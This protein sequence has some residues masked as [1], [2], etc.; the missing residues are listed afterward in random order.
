MSTLLSIAML[1][2]LYVPAHAADSAESTE[3]E[4]LTVL[5]LQL[6]AE[7]NSTVSM[8]DGELWLFDSL[9]FDW[10]D[11]LSGYVVPDPNKSGVWNAYFDA[12]EVETGKSYYAVL[13]PGP[14]ANVINRGYLYCG[15]N[16]QTPA[17]LYEEADMRRIQPI[18]VGGDTALT[19]L[20]ETGWVI[21][22]TVLA[23]GGYIEEDSN[24]GFMYPNICAY[25]ENEESYAYYDGFVEIRD[26][27]APWVYHI[28]VPKEASSYMIGFGNESWIND[29]YD[30]NI[31]FGD[32]MEAGPVAVSGDTTGPGLQMSLVGAVVTGTVTAPPSAGDVE[33]YNIGA[34]IGDGMKTRW[35]NCRENKDGSWQ[36]SI[37]FSETEKN[38]TFC[39]DFGFVED[40]IHQSGYLAGESG[41][42]YLTDDVSEAARF[43]V[44]DAGISFALP[45]VEK[46]ILS[47]HLLPEQGG[48]LLPAGT[49]IGVELSAYARGGGATPAPSG[50]GG[51]TPAPSGGG[52]VTPAPSGGG[53]SA[54]APSGGSSGG[55]STSGG[56]GTASPVVIV[57]VEPLPDAPEETE[58]T[59]VV[60][61]KVPPTQYVSSSGSDLSVYRTD[62]EIDEDGSWRAV[63]PKQDTGW[64]KLMI[65]VPN[66]PGSGV[67]PGNYWYTGAD[68][69]SR[70]ESDAAWLPMDAE[71][72][73]VY[74]EA[75]IGL[76]GAITSPEGTE[77][78]SWGVNVRVE[79]EF[80]SYFY[81][82]IDRTSS[83]CEYEFGFPSSASDGTF[84]LWLDYYYWDESDDQEYDSSGYL[85]LTD[86]VASIVRDREDATEFS[87]ADGAPSFQLPA[88]QRTTVKVRLVSADGDEVVMPDGWLRLY[89]E[90][91]GG[92]R[93]IGGARLTPESDGVWKAALQSDLLSLDETYCLAVAP[94]QN[95]NVL[96][97]HL[98]FYAGEA[99]TTPKTEHTGIETY[100]S[101]DEV[102]TLAVETGWVLTGSVLMP[103]DGYLTANGH[104]GSF[105]ELSVTVI[106]ATGW[107][108][109]SGEA[110]REAGSDRWSYQVTVPKN[111]ETV[112]QVG[113]AANTWINR[114]YETNL[115]FMAPAWSE[116][117]SVNGSGRG[118]DVMLD[119]L[120]PTVTGVVTYPQN[121]NATRSL[122]LNAETRDGQQYDV[123]LSGTSNWLTKQYSISFPASTATSEYRLYVRG[124]F[125]VEG[126]WNDISGWLKE[127]GGVY[128]VE[129]EADDATWFSVADGAPSFEMPEEKRVKLYLTLTSTTGDAVDASAGV[130]HILSEDGTFGADAEAMRESDGRLSVSVL[131][132][133]L[134]EGERYY[135]SF[136]PTG[137]S[138]LLPGEYF[139]AGADAESAAC[140][141]NEAAPTTLTDG[142][143]YEIPV[144]TGW[145]FTG[146]VVVPEGGTV[147]LADGSKGWLDNVI[148]VYRTKEYDEYDLER[149]SGRLYVGSQN[150]PLLYE[151]VLP[152]EDATYQIFVDCRW[153]ANLFDSNVYLETLEP[154]PFVASETA[155]LPDIA[156]ERIGAT[157]TGSVTFPE[158]AADGD[159]GI[160]LRAI[161]G[162]GPGYN[163]SISL[164]ETGFQYKIEFPESVCEDEYR[165]H[166]HY[167]YSDSDG[168]SCDS[169]GY[170]QLKDG[171][172]QLVRDYEAATTFHASD[173]VPDFQ[174][175]TIEKIKVRVRL[176]SPDSEEVIMVNPWLHLGKLDNGSFYE[177]AQARLTA[178]SDGTWSAVFNQ[179]NISP[180]ETY[181][182][183]VS[184]GLDSNVID[185]DY[186]YCGEEATQPEIGWNA[187]DRKQETRIDDGTVHTI[188]VE[189]GWLITGAVRMPEGGYLNL[190]YDGTSYPDIPVRAAAKTEQ[191]VTQTYSGI[192]KASTDGG[193]WVYQIA[194]PKVSGTVYQVKTVARP[195]YNDNYDTN[196]AFGFSAQSADLTVNG[197]ENGADI[198]LE[199]IGPTV[200]GVV[201]FPQNATET[202]FN[203]Y[204]EIGKKEYYPEYD[205]ETGEYS[206]SFPYSAAGERY[207]LRV[208]GYYVADGESNSL[209]GWLKVSDGSFAVVNERS[210]A[211]WFAVADGA[212]SFE[213]PEEQ[214]VKIYLNLAS[215][216]G[217]EVDASR[218]WV[219][220]FAVDRFRMTD[221]ELK[222]EADGRWS[223]AI[224]PSA[225]MVDG[226][227]ICVGFVPSDESNVP[228]GVWYNTEEGAV[229]HSEDQ[230]E[231]TTFRDGG[232]YRLCVETGWTLTGR[233]VVP[234][235]AEITLPSS[236]EI[237]LRHSVFF[238][239][240]TAGEDESYWG[241]IRIDSQN[242]P[243]EYRVVLPKNAA[244]YRVYLSGTQYAGQYNT[245]VYLE[246]PDGILFDARDSAGLPDIALELIGA[247]LTGVIS[248]SFP[249]Q[250]F[251]I[252][253]LSAE[254]ESG[255]TY[256][257]TSLN[258]NEDGIAYRIDLP[259]SESGGDYRLYL[260][261]N[262]FNETAAQWESMSGWLLEDGEAFRLTEREGTKLRVSDGGCSAALERTVFADRE[263][264]AVIAAARSGEA[265][266]KRFYCGES[267]TV[268]VA[269]T[270][271]GQGRLL[272]TVSATPAPANGYE[273]AGFRFTRS[274]GAARV[275]FFQ[276]L[277]ESWI[278]VDESQ[279]LW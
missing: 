182:L 248:A 134:P 222:R 217:D 14:G 233:V 273:V 253:Y 140:Y 19:F 219:R 234:A 25:I 274:S 1:L 136:D 261:C 243:W 26:R 122:Y 2:S 186:F 106:D 271:D 38:E 267:D 196:L 54:P 57:P 228:A 257:A 115:A 4:E 276:F 277:R 180:D 53:G 146:R 202:S 170:L 60:S 67:R 78:N 103:A 95:T 265:I 41:S 230:A 85:R 245:N 223:A 177:A 192:A 92:Y 43:E 7:D 29:E 110:V 249:A 117:F 218:S 47:G 199:R 266:E 201:S 263:Q 83:R 216:S 197:S 176:T 79:P 70:D 258:E 190:R 90:R 156:L 148:S 229:V 104:N 109:S 59:V 126:V 171:A 51:S 124:Y 144:V 33:L 112:Y 214:K 160:G 13:Y 120:G 237:L 239:N 113:T 162:N 42:Y 16:A 27:T 127:N 65:K 198:T 28:A 30:T 111:A 246:N 191:G 227:R 242:G 73:N 138:N 84:R 241:H 94:G 203:L 152:K 175:P 24:G 34:A 123:E 158:D 35:A 172:V 10:D 96:N 208:N 61:A 62:V 141:T 157:L 251:N 226:E 247:T 15:E 56:G 159:W 173:T 275:T 145:V 8:K 174:L 139:Y 231:L 23:P 77:R 206:I 20:V 121:T 82:D 240:T 88:I 49:E 64:K 63:F 252:N 69:A 66:V 169:A 163:A 131:E 100:V 17:H 154:I 189:T 11:S 133:L 99:S 262:F 225:E 200:S 12:T 167:W 31:L 89:Q 221:A 178:E 147:T 132:R 181:C 119:H 205:F 80:E 235:G 142:E 260:S 204:A 75:G 71:N 108:V 9:E 211:T 129:Q 130:V 168:E 272:E 50:G 210:D 74:Y 207:R 6:K 40:G 224:S 5:T 116:P 128:S 264:D 166:L 76:T 215:M 68:T 278:P 102:Y 87:A 193:G 97:N 238:E 232:E 101:G 185:A 114:E 118:K 21:T 135:I 279:T 91:D 18:T 137:H 212:P 220:I 143:T 37:W 184:P 250:Y 39:L 150:E 98:Y 125:K 153:R 36:Y 161:S 155:S 213:M 259:V 22:G 269:A 183:M 194:V 195:W 209:D 254:T 164:S 188:P 45:E 107:E 55:A 165:L 44:K 256:P 72:V 93:E 244:R 81:A 179:G 149:Y 151:V 48:A 86:G 105:P 52:G 32:Y 268:V 46:T 270:Y 236:G 255:K 187:T 58:E 3:N